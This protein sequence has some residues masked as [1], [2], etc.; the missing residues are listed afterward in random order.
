M[1]ELESFVRT[2]R[3]NPWETYHFAYTSFSEFAQTFRVC[4]ARRTDHFGIK[5][6]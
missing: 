3:V 4:R 2:E 1:N 5:I 6:S